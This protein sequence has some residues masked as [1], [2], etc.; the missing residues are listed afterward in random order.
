MLDSSVVVATDI[1]VTRWQVGGDQVLVPVRLDVTHV[2]AGV[3]L[4]LPHADLG[5]EGGGDGPVDLLAVDVENGT[6]GLAAV[7]LLFTLKAEDLILIEK[8]GEFFLF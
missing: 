6:W 4:A 5:D 1:I 3:R 8:D 7:A 2:L